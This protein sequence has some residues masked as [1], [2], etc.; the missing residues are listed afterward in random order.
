MPCESQALIVQAP[1]LREL[2]PRQL[3]P[4]AEENRKPVIASDALNDKLALVKS[5]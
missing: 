1:K 5:R 4:F 2:P 3:R